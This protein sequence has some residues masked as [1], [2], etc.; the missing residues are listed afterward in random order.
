MHEQDQAL[1]EA[2]I[3]DYCRA[4]HLQDP[5][6]FS[7][8]W[9]ADTET[10]LISF[11]TCY[12]GMESICRDFLMGSIARAYS[13]I[14]LV[15]QQISVHFPGPDTAVAIF[16]YSTDS[17]RRDS[18]APYGIRGLETQVWVRRGDAWKVCHVQYAKR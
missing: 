10:T 11:G 8:L 7:A 5:D 2:G 18:G 14:D 16:S 6:A 9:A 3:F 1:I 4:V 12:V 17:I 15:P 13:R